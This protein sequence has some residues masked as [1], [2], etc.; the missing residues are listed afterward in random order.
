MDVFTQLLQKSTYNFYNVFRTGFS[1]VW[2][3]SSMIIFWNKKGHRSV[4]TW[5][6]RA[7]LE[8]D[9]KLYQEKL[10]D[11]NKSNKPEKIEEKPNVPL[12]ES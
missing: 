4:V 8:D 5:L 12:N 6:S 1:K 11:W 9:K 7:V 10:P 3:D 2:F